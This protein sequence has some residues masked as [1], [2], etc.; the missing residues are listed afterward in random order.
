MNKTK[1]RPKETVRLIHEEKSKGQRRRFVR[2]DVASPFELRKLNLPP[3][4]G[5]AIVDSK[6]VLGVILNISGGGILVAI[7]TKLK[8]NSYVAITLDMAGMEK[9]DRILGK[10]KRADKVEYSEYLTG[11]EF[12]G[13]EMVLKE[14]SLTDQEILRGELFSFNE[15]IQTLILKYVLLEKDSEKTKQDF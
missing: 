14:L 12:I 10:V 13:P 7:D 11:I 1:T 4:S 8:V 15:R 6:R 9:V 2:L 5:K 3:K